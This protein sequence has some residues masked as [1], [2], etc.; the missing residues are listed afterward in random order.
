MSPGALCS[1]Q[2]PV[3]HRECS[4]EGAL[5]PFGSSLRAGRPLLCPPRGQGRPQDRAHHV[6]AHH[7][8]AC[9]GA[10]PAES[11]ACWPVASTSPMAAAAE[12]RGSTEPSRAQSPA[13]PD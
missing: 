2:H 3:H 5:A 12:V 7:S 4:G 11:K 10:R 1:R 13:Q 6:K 8:T 9:H